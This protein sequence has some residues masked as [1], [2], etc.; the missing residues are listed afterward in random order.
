MPPSHTLLPFEEDQLV[1]KQEALPISREETISLF[2]QLCDT[3]V[4]KKLNLNYLTW[5]EFLWRMMNFLNNG[6]FTM[7]PHAQSTILYSMNGHYIRNV[8]ARLAVSCDR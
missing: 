7:R 8:Y 4:S 6:K 2:Q 5:K 1:M 3:V